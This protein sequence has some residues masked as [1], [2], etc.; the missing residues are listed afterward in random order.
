MAS[1]GPTTIPPSVGIIPLIRLKASLKTKPLR[2][3]HRH[4]TP[5][6]A[7]LMVA[8]PPALWLEA[9]D[10]YGA[11]SIPTPGSTFLFAQPTSGLFPPSGSSGAPTA[12]TSPKWGPDPQGYRFWP[13]SHI[14]D[15]LFIKFISILDQNCSIDIKCQIGNILNS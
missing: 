14:P 8:G 11:G 12:P 7:P 2:P 6:P 13:I 9:T 10:A 15:Y 5:G 1:S 4:R 3:L